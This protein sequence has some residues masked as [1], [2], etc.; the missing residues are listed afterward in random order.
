MMPQALVLGRPLVRLAAVAGLLVLTACSPKAPPIETEEQVDLERFMGDWYVIAHIPAPL[1]AN[2]YN[3]VESYRKGEDG[4]I[5]TTFRFRDGG[6]GGEVH[7]YNP[8]GFV[9]PDSGNA[10]WAMQ[11]FWPVRFEYRIVYL[12]DSYTRTI[13]GRRARDYAWLMARSPSLPEAEYHKL[14]EVLDER[15]YDTEK[16]RRVPQQWPENRQSGREGGG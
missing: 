1:E 4:R 8:V 11:F 7:T 13:I 14:V 12:N 15:G 9:Q 6:F 16:L 2:A 3:A 5:A 10:V